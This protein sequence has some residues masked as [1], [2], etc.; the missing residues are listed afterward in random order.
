MNEIKLYGKAMFTWLM[1]C[2]G[3]IF[4]LSIILTPLLTTNKII[5]FNSYELI[6]MTLSYIGAFYV[7]K[8][9]ISKNVKLEISHNKI[10]IKYL[11][12]YSIIIMSIGFIGD[13]VVKFLNDIFK[14]FGFYF[15]E[16]NVTDIFSYN[17]IYEFIIVFIYACIVAPILEE[18]LFRGYVI[19]L[20][21]KYGKKTAI[22]LSACMFGITHAEFMQIIPAIFCG[23]ILGI[24]YIKTNNIK[25][26]IACHMINNIFG[27]INNYY[28]NLV[29]IIISIL[30]IIFLSR[31]E[32][33]FKITKDIKKDKFETKYIFSSIPLMLF[34]LICII[35]SL[36]QIRLV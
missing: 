1:S 24:L 16:T 33:L 27:I 21:K 5:S 11:L 28:I 3:F 30:L 23:I 32:N 15:I 22:I 10:N 8:K 35:I 29:I 34:I 18:L 31:K 17:N 2:Y 25:V 4:L 13:Y 19:N 9:V 26:C 6:I 36:S 20:F 7:F 12:I 14:F